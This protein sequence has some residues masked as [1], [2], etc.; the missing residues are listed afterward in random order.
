LAEYVANYVANHV[1][2]F[3]ESQF[4]DRIHDQDIL[5]KTRTGFNAHASPPINAWPGWFTDG[6]RVGQ[7]LSSYTS[8]F[9]GETKS[10]L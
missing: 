2:A 5:N 9:A 3:A 8:R 6:S 10:G 1:G 4:A 7:P